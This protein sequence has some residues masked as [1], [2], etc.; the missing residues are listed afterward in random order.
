MPDDAFA[1]TDFAVIAAVND[2]C[3]LDQCLARSP[4]I[5]SG[6]LPLIVIRGA[7]NMASAYNSGL[8]QWGGRIAL[9]A[10]QDVYLPR[11]W[12]DLAKFKLSQ[13][14][15]T[16]PDWMVAGPYGVR[17]D[18][19]HVGLVWDSGLGRELGA[20]GFG[21]DQIDSLDELLLI[22]KREDPYRFDE[23][24]PHFHL[25]GTD[26]VQSCL[27]MGKSAWAVEMP[28]VHNGQ[29]VDSL[30]GGY[31]LAY[32]YARRKWRDRLPIATTICRVSRNPYYLWRAK[33]AVRK[34]PARTGVVGYDAVE[35][36]R[37]LGYEII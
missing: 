21:F 9:F 1:D 31:T 20:P 22:L 4:D 36:A 11:G 26:L 10:H 24:L 5:V 18:G 17:P 8:D 2:D 29:R 19:S 28:V 13:L 35:V 14:Q 30:S 3:I 37:K 32:N 12:L 15:R 6:R 27:A 23:D 33:W 34:I 16:A 7:R 25:Y